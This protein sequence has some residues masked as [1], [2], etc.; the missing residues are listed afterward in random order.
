MKVSLFYVINMLKPGR[1]IKFSIHMPRKV[2]V[3]WS[4]VDKHFSDLEFWGNSHTITFLLLD[5]K[6]SHMAYF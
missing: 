2:P 3:R 4:D 5:L 6:S 1:D